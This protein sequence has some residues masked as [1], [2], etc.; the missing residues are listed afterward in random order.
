MEYRKGIMRISLAESLRELMIKH[1]FE[2]ITIK[3]VCDEAGV[4]RATF[5]NYFNDKYDC[6]NWIIYHDICE[7]NE[8]YLKS[9]DFKTAYYN[10][11]KTIEENKEF[12][13]SAYNN[14]IG[15]N[16]FESILRNLLTEMFEKYFINYRKRG[17]LPNYSD[18][19]LAKYYSESI[20]FL[21]RIFVFEVDG[22]YTVEQIMQL[23]HDLMTHSVM[24]AI[25]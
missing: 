10:C 23:G 5:Y 7:N 3:Q 11:F 15:I 4:I 14:V 22:K 12:Y 8:E 21:I 2:K 25:K 18:E 9:G 17:F 20:A 6:L 13:R 16:S 1:V 24:D 19:L